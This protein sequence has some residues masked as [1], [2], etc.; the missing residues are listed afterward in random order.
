MT[1]ES[2]SLR[3]LLVQVKVENKDDSVY[4]GFNP[5]MHIFLSWS[6]PL[7]NDYET[8]TF[9]TTVTQTPLQEF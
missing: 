4:E 6:S 8:Q 1:G 2:F 9:L 7:L 3:L 5:N